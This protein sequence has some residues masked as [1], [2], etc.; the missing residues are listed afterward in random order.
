MFI[1]NKIKDESGFTL[2]GIIMGV[3]VSGIVL[4]IASQIFSSQMDTYSFITTRKTTLSDT[5][6][7]LNKISDELLTIETNDILDIDSDQFSFTDHAGNQTDYDLEAS[8]AS[9]AIYRGGEK[10]LD[11]VKSFQIKYYDQNGNELLAEAGNISSVRQFELIITTE[12][13][14]HEG[15]LTLSTKVTP[16]EYIYSN[17]Q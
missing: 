5:R 16:R 11:N 10:L 14:G 4:G 7:A 12:E 13:Q 15:E 6:Y 9:L 2:I 17:Y 8:G 3:V 1:L